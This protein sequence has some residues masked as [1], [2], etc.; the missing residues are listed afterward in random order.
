MAKRMAKNA[1]RAAEDK[2]SNEGERTEGQSRGGA[3]NLH[4]CGEDDVPGNAYGGVDERERILAQHFAEIVSLS[5]AK[6]AGPLQRI[7]SPGKGWR[8][9]VGAKG[10]PP[11]TVD[12]HRHPSPLPADVGSATEAE[13]RRQRELR[14]GAAAGGVDSSSRAEHPSLAASHKPTHPHA[15]GQSGRSGDRQG[16]AQ[17]GLPHGRRQPQEPD[18]RECRNSQH[19]GR[20][21][22]SEGDGGGRDSGRATDVSCGEA[23]KRRQRQ[24]RFAHAQAGADKSAA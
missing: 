15:L 4:D 14:F 11:E 17:D 12:V 23:H 21:R 5:P 7:Q 2:T 24:A 8:R 3:D 10:G 9:G 18:P 19:V 22:G 13:R 1:E 6:V 16:Q 20:G